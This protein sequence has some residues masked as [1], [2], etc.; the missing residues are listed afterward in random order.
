[1]AVAFSPDGMALLTRTHD[2][3][4]RFVLE[5]GIA[6]HVA[7]RFSPGNL[8]RDQRVHFLDDSGDAVRTAYHWTGSSII[9]KDFRF[10]VEEGTPIGGDPAAL[11]KKWQDRLNLI[12]EDPEKTTRIV[13]KYPLPKRETRPVLPGDPRR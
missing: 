7:T 11:L 12:F 6:R 13:E 4:H 2:R 5:D 9:V 8:P 10:D 3:L 1:M